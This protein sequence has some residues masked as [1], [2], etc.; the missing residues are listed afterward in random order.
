M[1][2]TIYCIKDRKAGAIASSL[3]LFEN[4]DVAVRWFHQVYA[5]AVDRDRN[6][7]LASYPEDFDL[8]SLGVLDLASGLIRSGDGCIVVCAADKF[9]FMEV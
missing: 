8:V 2:R 1:I 4:D 6:S 7:A 9:S 3:M 5:D